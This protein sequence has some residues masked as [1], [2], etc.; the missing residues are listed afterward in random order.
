MLSLRLSD[1]IKFTKTG[2]VDVTIKVEDQDGLPGARINVRDTGC[3][4]SSEQSA[5]IFEDF[6]QA[7]NQVRL[8]YGG[9]GLGLSISRKLVLA[10]GGTI[11][12]ES[13][14]G[15]GSTFSFWI[16]GFVSHSIRPTINKADA[17]KILLFE[18]KC[19][20]KDDQKDNEE[21]TNCT[22]AIRAAGF[23][24]LRISD[25]T[26]LLQEYDNKSIDAVAIVPHEDNALLTILGDFLDLNTPC[27]LLLVGSTAN[28]RES[29]KKHEKRIKVVPKFP[30]SNEIKQ[31]LSAPSHSEISATKLD[32]F[33][34]GNLKRDLRVLLAEDNKVN[35]KVMV[36][37]LSKFPCKVEVACNGLEAV[38]MSKKSKYDLILMDM[39]MP[40]MDGLCATKI[41][42]E[43]DPD[44][45][46]I[47]LTANATTEDRDNCFDAGMVDFLTK[48]ITLEALSTTLTSISNSISKMEQELDKC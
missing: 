41:I 21:E 18:Q 43:R 46:I 7:N 1:A 44:T 8:Q 34:I 36:R 24:V 20:P 2:G 17:G 4:I 33:N 27:G 32:I 11:N 39:F 12:V 48:P 14:L 45:P 42:R 47:A 3:G 10:M 38:E 25:V 31:A 15:K 19:D 6:T 22:S 5:R 29:L 26:Q 30:T 16:P 35:V 9:S 28:D 23:D 13:D 37:L 40:E